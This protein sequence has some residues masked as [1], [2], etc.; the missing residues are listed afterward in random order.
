MQGKLIVL[1]GIDGSGKTTIAKLLAKSL[2]GDTIFIEKKC[3]YAQT[4][5]QAKFMSQVKPI[6]W[7]RK[8][9]E[10]LDEIDEETWLYLHMCWYHMVEAYILR[11][12]L[13][14]HDFVVMDGW[15]YKFL[16][17]HIVN[18]KME[19]EVANF[20]TKRLVLADYIF[21]LDVPPQV[22]YRRKMDT[23][24][25]ECG[26]HMHGKEIKSVEGLFVDYQSRVRSAYKKILNN[27]NT[28]ILDAN[29]APEVLIRHMMKEI[30]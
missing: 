8:A 2:P 18:D 15:Y 24:P 5:F 9:Q 21:F 25:S 29:C 4:D 19:I 13:Q 11:P 28:H 10:P 14:Q 12:K 3:I 6:I 16:A 7:E 23:K 27:R 30:I 26:I 1:E 22:C 20:L 17:R